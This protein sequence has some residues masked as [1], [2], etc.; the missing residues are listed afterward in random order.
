MLGAASLREESFCH[1]GV[2][3]IEFCHVSLL[4][5]RDKTRERVPVD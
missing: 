5:A 2:P 3:K 1:A 4:S